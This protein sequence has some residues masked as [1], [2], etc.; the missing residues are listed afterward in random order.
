MSEKSHL[1]DAIFDSFAL[2]QLDF[3]LQLDAVGV[4]SQTEELEVLREYSIYLEDF[5][6]QWTFE[7]LTLHTRAAK[8]LKMLDQSLIDR[9]LPAYRGD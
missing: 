4:S 6:R 8:M 7:N 1:Y 2:L 5:S 9:V 3:A